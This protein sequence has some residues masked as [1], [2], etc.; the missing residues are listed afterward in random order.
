M[1]AFNHS[2]KFGAEVAK[3]SARNE[4]IAK[5]SLKAKSR[6]Y[7]YAPKE[8]MRTHCHDLGVTSYLEPDHMR[9]HLRGLCEKEQKEAWKARKEENRATGQK[10]SYS[11]NY[12][13]LMPRRHYPSLGVAEPQGL[14]GLIQHP[15]PRRDARRLGVDE[16]ARKKTLHQG[17]NA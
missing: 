13:V 11:V 6:A 5:K 7:A 2:A 1:F 8:P 15:M 12:R 14:F 10:Q 16:A 9:T 17:L 3:E 4:K